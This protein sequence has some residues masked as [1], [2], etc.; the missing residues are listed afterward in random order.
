[1]IRMG[2]LHYL[3]LQLET[4]LN[5]LLMQVIQ[6]KMRVE[7]L[8]DIALSMIFRTIATDDSP[9][10]LVCELRPIL[11]TLFSFKPNMGFSEVIKEIS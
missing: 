5:T 10:T 11:Y 3:S 7:C 4:S 1:M 9:F 6:G 8:S 2:Q